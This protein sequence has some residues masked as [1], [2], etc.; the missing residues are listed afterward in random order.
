M[1][2]T[3]GMD[4]KRFTKFLSSEEEARLAAILRSSEEERQILGSSDF[5]WEEMQRELWF[6]V[7]RKRGVQGMSDE[8]IQKELKALIGRVRTRAG[9]SQVP[10]VTPHR[11]GRIAR[12]IVWFAHGS[13]KRFFA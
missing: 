3:S 10:S 9:F 2:S 1:V 13:R 4:R 12:T 7:T 11:P 8:G 5:P 6:S